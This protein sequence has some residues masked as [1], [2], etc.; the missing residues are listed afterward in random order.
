MALS[1]QNAELRERSGS[2]NS[3]DPLVSFIYHLLRDHLPAGAVEGIMQEHLAGDMANAQFCNGYLAQYAKDI[4][5]R[6]VS[7]DPE[8]SMSIV[9]LLDSRKRKLNDVYARIAAGMTPGVRDEL[10]AAGCPHAEH[11]L[12]MSM[13]GEDV[14]VHACG[15]GGEL[16][17]WL[18]VTVARTHCEDL[19]AFSTRVKK[20]VVEAWVNECSKKAEVQP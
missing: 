11:L 19:K 17:R 12:L 18:E 10:K 7:Q 13:S 14:T 20:E 2:V 6:L 5:A 4:S 1:T 9:E 15:D 3:K 8:E 16:L